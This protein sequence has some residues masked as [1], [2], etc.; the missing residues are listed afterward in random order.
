MYFNARERGGAMKGKNHSARFSGQSRA[1]NG[2]V[3]MQLGSSVSNSGGGS[4]SG[5]FSRQ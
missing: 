3:P 2:P 5:N 4:S 1:N